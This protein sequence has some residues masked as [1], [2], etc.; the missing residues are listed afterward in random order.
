MEQTADDGLCRIGR[1]RDLCF[2]FLGQT[3]LQL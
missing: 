2:A 1:D 3:T